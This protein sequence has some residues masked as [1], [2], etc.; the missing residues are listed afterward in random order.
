MVVEYGYSEEVLQADKWDIANYPVL[1]KQHSTTVILRQYQSIHL[2]DDKKQFLWRFDSPVG[3]R[4]MVSKI[5]YGTCTIDEDNEINDIVLEGYVT[6][7]YDILNGETKEVAKY[8]MRPSVSHFNKVW[9]GGSDNFGANKG[10]VE[11]KA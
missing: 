6:V 8:H 10:Y 1:Y 2:S 3:D 5:V 11:H 7:D 9:N 4:R